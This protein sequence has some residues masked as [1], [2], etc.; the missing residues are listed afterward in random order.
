LAGDGKYA[1][2]LK[3]PLLSILLLDLKMPGIDGFEV[4][5]WISSS[6]E[7]KRL[8]IVVLNGLEDI[9]SINRAYDLGANSYLTKPVNHADLHNM[10]SFFHGY[11]MLAN[12]S[13]ELARAD[14]MQNSEERRTAAASVIVVDAQEDVAP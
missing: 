5:K 12:R 11:W 13:P 6:P 2:R 10:V 8:L 1:D 9:N 14:E 3:Y 7:L 4:L